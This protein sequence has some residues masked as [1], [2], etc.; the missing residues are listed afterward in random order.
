MDNASIKEN[1]RRFR[2]ERKM[3]QEEM[4]DMLC[5]SIT[6]YRDLREAAHP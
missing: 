3:T 6:A 4:A 5:I 1:I 2:K